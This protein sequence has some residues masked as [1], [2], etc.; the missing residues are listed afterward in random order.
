[1]S[2][3]GLALLTKAFNFA[4]FKHRNQRRKY[5]DLPYINHPV[6]VTDFLSQAG[7][8]DINILCAA[9]LHDTVEDT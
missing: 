2:I 8:T 6:E 1:M 7:V 4:A 9:V 3:Q 5:G